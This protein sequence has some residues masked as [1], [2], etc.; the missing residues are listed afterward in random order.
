VSNNNIA[1][2]KGEN[3]ERRSGD[4]TVVMTDET[5]ATQPTAEKDDDDDD[6]MTLEERLVWLREHVSR[7]VVL[8]RC[9]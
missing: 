2:E 5:E 1:K 6:N 7:F 8:C 9:C 3:R 4:T